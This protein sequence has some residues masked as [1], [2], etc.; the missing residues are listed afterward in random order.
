MRNHFTFL[1]HSTHIYLP[2][3][4]EQTECS[5]TPVYK[6][7]TPGNYPKES[8]QHTEHGESLKSRRVEM[9]EWFFIKISNTKFH[10]NPYIVLDLF[11]AYRAGGHGSFNEYLVG[12]VN[13]PKKIYPNKT[14]C[15]RCSSC[16]S[17]CSHHIDIMF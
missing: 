1:V 14:K 17:M 13:V 9:V 3:K 8:I 2:M 12:D 15:S 16:R 5:E 4:M 6:L 7:Q 11:H 10:Q